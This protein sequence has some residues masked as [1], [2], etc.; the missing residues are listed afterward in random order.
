MSGC[1]CGS[2][3]CGCSSSEYGGGGE[4]SNFSGPGPKAPSCIGPG[5]FCGAALGIYPAI[6]TGHGWFILVGLAVGMLFGILIDL[7]QNGEVG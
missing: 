1:G 3:S 4:P 2:G 7:F 6:F 5:A